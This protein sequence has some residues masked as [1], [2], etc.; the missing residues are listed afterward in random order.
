MKPNVI[1]PAFVLSLTACSTE[2][3]LGEQ[4]ANLL[5]LEVQGLSFVGP[6]TIKSGWTTIRVNNTGGMTHHALVYR[7]PDGITAEMV[8]EQIV[9]PIQRILTA[10]IGGDTEKAA[11]IAATIPAWVG[12]LVWMGGPGMMSDG[13]TGEATMYL[14]PGNYI[15]E[16]YVKTDGVQHNYNPEPGEFG[17]MLPLTVVAEDGGMAEPDANVT[18]TL[19]NSGYEITD[20]AFRAGDNDVRVK[21]EEQRLY[22]NFVG[23]DAHVFRIDDDTDVD[24]AVRWPDFF[25][26]EGQQTPA[27]A[28]FVGGIHDMPQGATGYFKLDLEPGEYGI[29]A[30]IPDAAK[31]GFFK[32]FSV[33]TD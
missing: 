12:D 13:V 3:L 8:D 7:L 17:M 15:L 21:F 24:A 10:A 18:L 26:T 19:T 9:E 20:G 28:R 16:C 27:P 6:D 22:N 14:E 33:D 5:E 29:T 23:H 1:L 32:R 2:P 11:E 25:P 4:P 30:E 31:N